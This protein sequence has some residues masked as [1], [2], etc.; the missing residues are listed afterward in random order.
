MSKNISEDVVSA[1]L[2]GRDSP[3]VNTSKKTSRSSRKKPK[4]SGNSTK[5]TKAVALNRKGG[6]IRNHKED[7]TDADNRLR[8]FMTGLRST[9]LKNEGI[10][11]HWYDPEVNR[12]YTLQEIADIMGVSRERVRQVEEQALRKLWR[13]LSIMNKR[14]GM[15]KDDWFK[16]FN[17][18]NNGEA[19][20]Y[21]P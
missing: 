3:L 5:P 9:H 13:Y 17:E 4:C 8:E 15:E 11:E 10:E 12:Q 7:S 16:T 14:E 2:A 6:L 19:T 1:L 21:M 20:I 18:N